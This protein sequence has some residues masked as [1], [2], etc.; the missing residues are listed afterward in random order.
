LITC[1]SA[2]QLFLSDRPSWNRAVGRPRLRSRCADADV[3][4]CAVALPDQVANSRKRGAVFIARSG[5]APV[6]TLAA[7]AIEGD[8][9]D[10]AAAEIDSKPYFRLRNHRVSLS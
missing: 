5:N 6:Q 2:R 7:C 1:A 8:E 4:E 10:F 9:F 3:A